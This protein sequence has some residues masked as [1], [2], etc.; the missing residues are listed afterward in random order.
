MMIVNHPSILELPGMW[1]NRPTIFKLISMALLFAFIFG[2]SAQDTTGQR[3][4]AS[5]LSYQCTFDKAS[6]QARIQAVLQGQDGLALAREAYTLTVTDAA[7]QL[8]LPSNQVT[9]SL[10]PQRPPLQMILLLDVTDTVPIEQIV[11]AISSNL[12]PRLD[13]ADEVA[14][15]TFSED[16]TPRTQFYTD[17]GRLVNEHMID[18]LAI[19]GENRVY[20]AIYDTIEAFPLRNGVRQVILLVT[21]SGRRDTQQISDEEIINRAARNNQAIYSIAYFSRDIPDLN[22]LAAIA[23]GTHGYAWFY[24]DVPNTRSSI[25]NAVTGYLADFVTTLNSEILIAVDMQGIEPD[26]NNFVTFDLAVDLRNETILSDQIACEVERLQHAINFVDDIEGA[27]VNGV[28]DVGVIVNSDLADSET[29][30]VFRSNNEI[31]QD[32]DAL[33]YRFDASKLQPGYYDVGA[34]LLDL[35]GNILA[36][37]PYTIRLYA[38]QSLDLN[39]STP[40]VDTLAEEI[41]LTAST[42]AQYEMNPVQFMLAPLGQPELARAMNTTPQQ[43]INGTATVRIVDTYGFIRQLFP[44]QPDNITYEITA[45]VAGVQASDPAQALSRTP[46]RINV[47]APLAETSPIQIAPETRQQLDIAVPIGLIVFMLILNFLLYRAVGRARIRRI[48]AHPDAY[49]LTTQVMRLTIRRHGVQQSYPL[50]KKTLELGR[51][52]GNDINLGDD[53]NISRQHGVIMWRK[54]NWYYSNRKHRVKARVNGKNYS[55][56]CFVKL[57]PITEIVIG[58]A[59]I[60]FHSNT[61]TDVAEFIKTNI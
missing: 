51:G 11:T 9:V 53:P 26:A 19:E 56:Y 7:T 45:V 44:N 29:V 57:E 21:D 55:G 42:N 12:M 5:F 37:T 18:L 40:M 59:L 31:V 54:Q 30:V 2:V 27:T 47:E 6:N 13:V 15:I 22:E 8:V 16:S 24:T 3:L 28:L 50:T 61:Q 17:K 36:T 60:V 46:L 39:I 41:T 34:Q 52:S 32:N 1:I 10:V 25:Q 4:T 38:Q 49:E 43:F 48:I 35:N 23:N 20:D 58:N 14:L 33:V